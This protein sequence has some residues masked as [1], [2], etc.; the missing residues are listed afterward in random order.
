MV[1][2]EKSAE[3]VGSIHPAWLAVAYDT[4]VGGWIRRFQSDPRWGRWSLQWAT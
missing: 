1:F 4:Q 3:Q 2:V